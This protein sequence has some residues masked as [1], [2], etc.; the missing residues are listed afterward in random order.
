MSRPICQ[1]SPQV[2]WLKQPLDLPTDKSPLV[3]DIR[4]QRRKA[5]LGFPLLSKVIQYYRRID[6]LVGDWW[7]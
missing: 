5:I 1:I 3:D 2:I 6:P 4:N 7:H